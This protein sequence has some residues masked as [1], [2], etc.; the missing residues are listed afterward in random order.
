MPSISSHTWSSSRCSTL[1]LLLVVLL[2][3]L[4]SAGLPV[5]Y[6]AVFFITAG[7]HSERIPNETGSAKQQKLKCITLRSCSFCAKTAET[8]MIDLQS[9]LWMGEDAFDGFCFHPPEEQSNVSFDVTMKCD[10]MALVRAQVKALDFKGNQRWQLC[11]TAC[12]RRTR[13]AVNSAC[14]ATAARGS[15]QLDS[16]H[17]LHLLQCGYALHLKQT[18]R[19]HF[20]GVN[21]RVCSAS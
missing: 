6:V 2:L 9:L 14:L 11:L 1:D 15:L 12:L 19:G 20:D 10:L 16:A 8:V 17:R 5:L 4:S 21:T 13:T 18:T 7:R 3:T